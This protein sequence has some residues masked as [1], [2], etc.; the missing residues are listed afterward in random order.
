[1]WNPGTRTLSPVTNVERMDPSA[2]S[3]TWTTRASLPT[4]RGDMGAWA[5]D[6]ST[7]YEI[8]GHIAIAGGVYPTPDAQGYIYTPGTN[9]WATWGSF[10]HPTRNYGVAQLAGF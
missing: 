9:S 4:A 6:S 5:Y 2:G 8:S 3:P 10:A 1:I 7:N